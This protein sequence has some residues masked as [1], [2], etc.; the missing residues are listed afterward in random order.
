MKR[1]L[2][3]AVL[4]SMAA[5]AFAVGDQAYWGMFAETSLQK[6]AG[7]PEM[8][9]MPEIDLSQ[10][11]PGMRDKMPHMVPGMGGPTRSFTIRLWS[12]GIAPAE[13]TASVAPPP[14]LKQGTKLDLELYRPKPGE[15]G[16]E[17]ESGQP[18]NPNMTI[19]FYWGSSPTVKPG[20]PK[21][22]TFGN[23]TPEQQG[24]MRRQARETTSYFYKENWTTGYWPTKQ[25]PGKIAKDA[26]LVGNYAL[27]TNYTGNVSID[28]P[29]N[30]NFLNP[31]TM[32]NPVLSE[33]IPLDAPIAFKWNPIP[34]LLGSH[35]M[36][37]GMEGQNTFILWSSSE[38]WQEGMMS[39]D[40]GYMQMAEVLKYVQDTVMMAGSRTNVTVPASIFKNCDFVRFQM[41]GY[42]PGA[43]RDETQPLPRIQTKTSLTIMLGGKMMQGM[44]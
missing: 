14:G 17:G 11:P 28:C 37:F 1:I 12:P 25:Q 7:M 16:G 42:G 9:Q 40:W 39:V 13:A 15:T 24:A 29:A 35:A 43:A 33:A 44:Q 27:T 36:I 23:L 4:L 20:Q 8:P 31:I 3:I 34:N 19:K 5:C 30:V 32:T 2:L 38:V 21:V 10:L 22:F 41:T 6:T 26:S 18:A